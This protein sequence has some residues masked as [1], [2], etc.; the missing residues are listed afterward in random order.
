METVGIVTEY[1][2][3]HNG[4]LYHLNKAKEKTGCKYVVSVMSGNFVQRGEPAILDKWTRA[5][6]AIDN[7]VD[8]VFEIPSIYSC[9][10]AEFYAEGSIKLLDGLGFIDSL[11]FGSE[12][13][14]IHP[15]NTISNLLIKEPPAF[16]DSLKYYLNKGLPFP[17]ARS[18]ALTKYLSKYNLEYDIDSILSNPNNIL[19]IEYLKTLNSIKS[20]IRPFTIKRIGAHYNSTE[21][22]KNIS[23]ATAIR[24]EILHSYDLQNISGFIPN[25][26]YLYIKD[27]LKKYNNVNSLENYTKIILYLLSTR[28]NQ[29]LSEIM[30][31]DEGLDNRIIK[32]L[33]NYSSI[34]D[35]LD[36]IKTKRYTFTRLQRILIH[37]LLGI[38]QYTFKE[39]HK[40]GPQYLRLLGASKNGLYLLSKNKNSCK[41][42]IITKFADYKK[43]SSLHLE[44]MISF[45]IEATNVYFLGLNSNQYKNNLD[46]FVS[47]YIK[48][49]CD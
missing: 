40:K 32:Y 38:D 28:H 35:F 14:S 31:I 26:C 12:C 21:L 43:H 39:L 18:H 46:F 3:F 41:L 42:P 47:P 22:D 20:N 10:S 4:H 5:K 27:F 29:F 30:D 25:N 6:M 48:K 45:D 17:K 15:L 49:E 16:K 37:L 19:G 34:I 7:G 33:K 1:N 8:L 44:K 36:N 24:K 13:G 2:P 23:S 11:C 9:Q